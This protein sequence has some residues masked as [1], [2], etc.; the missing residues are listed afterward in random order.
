[1]NNMLNTL[2][3]SVRV[4]EQD[5]ICAIL[6]RDNVQQP[7]H[8][9][10]HETDTGAS[11]LLM[12]PMRDATVAGPALRAAHRRTGNY[13]AIKYLIDTI[14]SEEFSTRHVQGQ[15]AKR[16]RLLHEEQTLIVPLMRGGE[17]MAQGVSKAFPLAALVHAHAPTDIDGSYL[18]SRFTIILVDSVVNS[19]KTILQ[20]VQHIRKLRGSI[21]IV[22]IA[23]VIQAQFLNLDFTGV[24]VP[25]EHLDFVAIR[26]STNKYT[27]KGTTDTGNRLFNTTYLR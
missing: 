24:L 25:Y 22:I 23:G 2:L 12:T 6:H 8:R 10:Q 18:E 14:G 4:T 5:F 20:F 21:R 26:L 3:P 9:F 15:T 11:K 1:M 7:Q 17:P 19:G 13:L 16:F 27:G